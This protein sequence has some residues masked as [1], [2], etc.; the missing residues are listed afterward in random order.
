MSK[1]SKL[2][3]A[4]QKHHEATHREDVGEPVMNLDASD[5]WR[6][7]L[8]PLLT[9]EQLERLRVA[10]VTNDPRL[11]Q[12]VTV[13]PRPASEDDPGEAT[14]G[15]LIGFC[16]MGEYR[17]SADIEGYFAYTCAEIDTRMSEQAAARHL[18]NFWDDNPRDVVRADLLTEVQRTL[19]ERRADLVNF[20]EAKE[21]E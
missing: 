20:W 8:A 21:Q 17:R 18:L 16:A 6:K 7:G 5:V 14:A 15:C 3:E 11:E 2:A 1:A 4:R 9:L 19:A 12:G 10:L 13:L